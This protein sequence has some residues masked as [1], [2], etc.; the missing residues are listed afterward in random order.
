MINFMSEN[1][2]KQ[3][4]GTIVCC[5][6]LAFSVVNAEEAAPAEDQG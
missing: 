1:T 5:A 4:M 6:G 2:L 3:I